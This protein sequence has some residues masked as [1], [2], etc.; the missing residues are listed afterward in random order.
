MSRTTSQLG[1]A[2][3]LPGA[4]ANEIVDPEWQR[5]IDLLD[6]AIAESGHPVWMSI[7]PSLTARPA[8]AP[9][10]DRAR[11][12][13]DHERAGNLA[14]RLAAAV[15]IVASEGIDGIDMIR[16]AITRDHDGFDRMSRRLRIPPDTVAVVAQLAAMPLLLGCARLLTREV[17][18][19]W[20]HGYCPVCGAWP[21]L[22]EMRGI[23]RARCLRCGCCGAGWSLP[24]LHCA[25]CDEVDHQRLGSLL[26]EGQEQQAHVETCESCHGYLKAVTTL[27][28]LQF[29]SLALTDLETIP[30]DLAAQDRGYARP[31]QAGWPLK[32]ELVA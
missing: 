11:L 26:L 23:E 29:R 10:L 18:R 25:F 8:N 16:S 27:G 6:M 21:M 4:A 9:L 22:V 2:G 31:S 5:W 3:G 7:P 15:G 1:A 19:S 24:V 20:D 13:V 12:H 17:Q 30:I 14:R 28:A 32:I